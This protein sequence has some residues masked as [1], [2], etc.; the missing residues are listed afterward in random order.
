MPERVAAHVQRL[1]SEHPDL[2][3]RFT[4][5]IAPDSHHY[6]NRSG[7]AILFLHPTHR[8]LVEEIRRG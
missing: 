2:E 1:L 3:V 7:R 5:A 8:R 6:G 4:F